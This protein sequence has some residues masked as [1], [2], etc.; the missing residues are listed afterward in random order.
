MARKTRLL[1]GEQ[2][3]GAEVRPGFTWHKVGVTIA[4]GQSMPGYEMKAS[5]NPR[6][7][8]RTVRWT[9][10]RA[11]SGTAYIECNAVVIGKDRTADLTKVQARIERIASSLGQEPV[12]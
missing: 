8:R 11:T 2:V 7:P 12:T 3:A 4:E 10:W 5:I 1:D 6:D 9:M